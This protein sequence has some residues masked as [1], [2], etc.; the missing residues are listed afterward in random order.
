MTELPIKPNE[1]SAP[2]ARVWLLDAPYALDRPFDYYVPANLRERALPGTLALVPFGGGNRKQ[3][4]LISERTDSVPEHLEN[5]IK[6]ID[7]LLFE[8][9]TLNGEF[10]Q[11]CAFLREYTLCTMGDA[12]RAVLPPAAFGQLCQTATA[13]T[14][15]AP[16]DLSE[17]ILL[18]WN[19]LQRNGTV[20][21]S[22]LQSKFGENVPLM[23]QELQKRGCVQLDV[24]Y[25]GSNVP[26]CE[27]YDCALSAEQIAALKKG[28]NGVT[29][30]QRNVLTAAC[31]TPGMRLDEL[32]KAGGI[33]TSGP[34][35]LLVEK[36]YLIKRTEQL[37]KDPYAD[38]AQAPP[39]DNTLSAH[40]K[41]AFDR[42]VKEYHADGARAVLLHGITGSGK[43]RV[44]KAVMD[45]VLQSGKQVIM[46]VPEISLTPQTVGYFRACYG[47]RVAVIH[48]GLSAG[49][50]LSS[51]NRI[52]QGK[53]DLCIGTRSAVFA[54]FDRLGLIV[55]DEEQEHTYK[56]DTSPRYHTRDVA[57]FRCGQ[58]GALMLLASATPS[59]ESYYKAKSGAYTLVSLTERY[60]DATLPEACIVDMRQE[61]ANGN[62]SPFGTR[63]LSE[64]QANLEKKEQSIL[65][66]SRRGYH[67]FMSCPQCGTAI[68]CPHCSVS[69]THH[70][71]RNAK[72]YLSCHYCGLR[73]PIPD[74][75]PG[76]G[77][78]HLRFMGYGTQMGEQ[79]LQAAFPQAKITRMD[80]DTTTTKWAYY[81]ILERFRKQEFD[82]LLGT[83]MVTKGHDFPNVTLSGVANADTALFLDDFRS[84]ERTYSM[85]AQ[86][87]GRAGRKDKK[88]RAV[89]QTYNPDHPVIRQAAMQNYEAFYENEI[90]LRHSLLFPPF[91]DIAL[92]TLTS[93]DERVV[94]KAAASLDSFIGERQKNDYADVVMQC[95]G[96]FEAPIYR[97]NDKY[98]MR[99]VIKCK[100]NRRT[101]AL[102]RSVLNEFAQDL[103]RRLTVTVDI[104]PAHL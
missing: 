54:P 40:Q 12:V 13:I 81:D 104:N 15:E 97:L 72:D 17:P 14:D 46:M 24:E 50:R 11:L 63:L 88:G 68:L 77:G 30:K 22:R 8:D 25:R 87:L 69:M 48:S 49:E 59:V 51:F 39:D 84:N 27:L 91:C 41:A 57:A 52:R 98:R 28:K 6:P 94:T 20:S 83:Q 75:C 56:S 92:I 86:V 76:C 26:H 37:E 4:A 42:I 67:N 58:H 101:R 55:M 80:A 2:Y 10:L 19:H 64:I 103:I 53:V 18:L 70:T 100:N 36:G 33:A 102:L 38:I 96:P 66:L 95:F 47:D 44:I 35:R 61:T 23:L 65:F 62:H 3:Y 78:R 16:Q 9:F 1:L 89:I 21:V 32:Q 31:Q 93:D 71:S 60:G 99:M 82:I 29:D 79:A 43:T 5:R 34:V 73:Q 45:E 90:A 74:V 85:I 7:S